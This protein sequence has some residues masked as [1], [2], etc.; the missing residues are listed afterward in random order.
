M[1]NAN[2]SGNR[3]SLIDL[4]EELLAN[5]DASMLASTSRIRPKLGFHRVHGEHVKIS[6]G[7]KMAKRVESFC[8]GLAFS[9][10]PIEI[11][12]IVCIKFSEMAT[13]WSGVL[14]FGVT[15][16]D[17]ETLGNSLPRFACPDLTS[18]EGNWAKALAERYCQAQSILHF[19]VREN[20]EL[21]YG[22][23]GVQKGLF[24]SGINTRS[25]MWVLVDIYG[26]SNCLEFLGK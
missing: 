21:Y 13:N 1:G 15:N 22:V 25:P 23:N 26:N 4:P 10:R 7:G 9:N 14:R 24:L 12:E 5:L 2:A 16:T 8:K 11:D 6:K 20:G 17:P 3:D 19:Y 18:K